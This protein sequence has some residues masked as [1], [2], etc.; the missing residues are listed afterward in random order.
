MQSRDRRVAVSTTRAKSSLSAQTCAVRARVHCVSA[1]TDIVS[2][3][4]LCSTPGSIS[5]RVAAPPQSSAW[6]PL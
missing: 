6:T 5:L 4:A 1:L 2:P 3:S